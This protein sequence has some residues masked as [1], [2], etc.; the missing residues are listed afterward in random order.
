[1]FSWRSVSTVKARNEWKESQ[2]GTKSDLSFFR[3]SS[4]YS[5]D[6]SLQ[7]ILQK[8]DNFQLLRTSFTNQ[9]LKIANENDKCKSIVR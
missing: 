5:D 4:S 8:G 3:E 7:K 1:M 2:R 9:F 6:S